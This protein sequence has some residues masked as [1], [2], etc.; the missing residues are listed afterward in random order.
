M[1]DEKNC[2]FCLDDMEEP[3]ISPCKCNG[4]QKYVHK[5][6]LNKWRFKDPKNFLQCNICKT[7]YQL[8]FIN[9]LYPV[10][11]T[12]LSAIKIFIRC[13]IAILPIIFL[14]VDTYHEPPTT[15]NTVIRLTFLAYCI[16][17]ILSSLDLFY[18]EY[19]LDNCD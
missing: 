12:T 10:S 14:F 3:L 18:I 17:V 13:M 19:N 7:C 5:T 9:R 2:R 11:R 4:T 1:S 6:C 8:N 15:S 16:Y